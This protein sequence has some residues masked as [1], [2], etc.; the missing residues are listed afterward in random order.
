MSM[1]LILELLV[2]LAR[3]HGYFTY[4]EP[5]KYETRMYFVRRIPWIVAESNCAE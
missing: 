5:V 4:H 3:M 1:H 2:M